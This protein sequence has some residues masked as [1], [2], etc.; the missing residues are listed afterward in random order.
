MPAG[1]LAGIENFAAV[2]PS[3]VIAA[4]DDNERINPLRFIVTNYGMTCLKQI[5]ARIL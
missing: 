4:S 2:D 3:G 1:S 5:L